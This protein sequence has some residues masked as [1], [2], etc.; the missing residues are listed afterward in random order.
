MKKITLLVKKFCLFCKLAKFRSDVYMR[1]NHNFF[2][3]HFE[4]YWLIQV[5]NGKKICKIFGIKMIL[6]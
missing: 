4:K 5:I 6:R 3:P 2:N 1:K